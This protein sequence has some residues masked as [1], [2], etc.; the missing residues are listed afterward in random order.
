MIDVIVIS[1]SINGAVKTV[2]RHHPLSH[3][4]SVYRKELKKPKE[5]G[6]GNGNGNE[7]TIGGAGVLGGI[8]DESEYELTCQGSCHVKFT[9][10]LNMA[11]IAGGGSTYSEQIYTAMIVPCNEGE[12]TVQKYDRIYLMMPNI[13]LSFEVVDITSTLSLI[14]GQTKLYTLQPV[15]QSVNLSDELIFKKREQPEKA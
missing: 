10:N 9:N 3:E 13:N 11:E 2:A 14:N 12:F 1:D 5:L 7:P 8:G 6:D 4:A 15:E